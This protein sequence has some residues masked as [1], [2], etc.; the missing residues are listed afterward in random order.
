[1][2][3]PVLH[4][5]GLAAIALLCGIFYSASVPPPAQAQSISSYTGQPPFVGSAVAPNILLLLDNSGSMNNNAYTTVFNTA[6]IYSGVFRNDT[7]Y[8]YASGVFSPDTSTVVTPP[9]I[10][11]NASYPWHG[12][13]LN[14]AAMREVDLVKVV[15]V[16]GYCTTGNRNA[17]GLCSQVKAQ[18]SFSSGACCITQF[19]SVTSA[20]A[21]GLMPASLISATTYFY[22]DGS[23]YPGKFCVS[24]SSTAPTTCTATKLFTGVANHP[25]LTQGVLQ[26]IGTA[27]RFALM[28]FNTS[29]GGNLSANMGSPISTLITAIEATTPSTWTPLGESLYEAVRYYAQISPSFFGTDYTTGVQANDPFYYAA[30]QWSATGQYVNCCKNYVIIFTD[31]QPTQDSSIPSAM[32]D[33]AHTA[34]SHGTS[35]HCS[36]ALGCTAALSHGGS[37]TTST[38]TWHNAHSEHHDNC[39]TYFGGNTSDPCLSAGS[40]IL[41]DVA[42][43]AHTTDLRQASIPI[44]GAGSDLPGLQNLTIYTFFAFGTGANLLKDAAKVGGFIDKNGNGLPDNASEY[45]QVNNITGALGADGVPDN[46]FEAVDAFQL[47]SSLIAT[48]SAILHDSSSGTAVS[49]LSSS[50]TGDG[51]MYQSYFYTSSFNGVNQVTWT[52]YTNGLFLDQYGNI[53]EDTDGDHRLVYTNDYIIQ[54]R[55][56]NVPTSPTYNQTLVDRYIDAN[57][58]GTADSANAAS[59]L[60]LNQLTGIWEAGRQLALTLSA[61]RN[62]ITWV[63]TNH[64]G[65]VDAS[66]Q[67]QFSLANA[68]TLGPYLRAGAAPYTQNAI[69]NFIRGCDPVLEAATCPAA[70]QNALRYR[71]LPVSGSNHIWKYGDP[72]SSSPTVVAAPGERF[73]LRYGDPSYN[74]FLAAYATR[75]EVVY[76]GANDGMLHAFNGGFYNRGDDPTTTSVEHG[77]F[78]N[79]S[80]PA[81][82]GV[83][84][85]DELWGFVPYQLLPQL[86]FLANPSY[87]HVYYVDLKPKVTDVRIFCD[88]GTNLSGN[89]STPPPT[90]I[91]GQAGTSHP[92]GW[93]TILIGGFRMGGSC[94]ACTTNGPPLTVTIGGTPITFYSAYFVLDITNPEQDPVLLWSFSDPTLGLTT[95][96][97]TVVRMNPNGDSTTS[98]TNAKWFA[99]FGSGVTGYDAPVSATLGQT[100]TLFAVDLVKGPGGTG[101]PNVAKMPV[102]TLHGIMGDLVAYDMDLDWRTDAIY[103][104]R[105]Y[106]NGGAPATGKMYRL[107]INNPIAGKT[108]CPSAPCTPATWGVQNGALRSPTEMLVTFPSSNTKY[109]GPILA[110]PIVTTDSSAKTWIYFGTGRYFS[111]PDKTNTETQYLFGLKDSVLN[112]TCPGGGASETSVTGCWDNNLLDVSNAVVCVTCTG[113]QVTGVAGGVTT[114]T[115]TAATSL[116][117]SIATLD[118]WFVTLPTTGER[119]IVTPTLVGGAVFFPTFTP[120]N[121]ICQASG[122]SNLYAL[123]YLTGTAYTTP[124]IGTTASG[125]QTISNRSVSLGSGVASAIS[126]QHTTSA[127]GMTYKSQMSTGNL[128]SGNA[129]VGATWSQYLSWLQQRN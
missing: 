26:Q 65:I 113:N 52:G 40:H 71:Y 105:Q 83:N 7:C 15:M 33:F 124:F 68:G 8:S 46:Y 5:Y 91:Q 21:A 17:Q 98:A 38:A 123:Y 23:N 78:T 111:T 37:A 41:D 32:Y 12:N 115:G 94:G 25:E 125:S 2:K 86:Q 36:A 48:I 29:Q 90:C 42:Y 44:L 51:S 4:H 64:N 70:E 76:V 119:N 110:A 97:P 16:G 6:T 85:G 77:W 101:N 50:S 14:F 28:E 102:G 116:Q 22:L 104:G 9:A 27:A 11:G 18:D 126:L 112:G 47:E 61:N 73:D 45:D 59:T 120:V 20:Q 34:A 35:D 63:D 79:H 99:V 75:R 24:S 43:F 128:V 87:T 107:I 129:A 109:P 55:F 1:M 95:S 69:I 72:I 121:D 60:S 62:L 108:G 56:D 19:Q 122:T 49:V 81:N 117:G 82:R 106:D 84:L 67:M 30:P 127:G 80:T 92:N 96:Y 89:P 114:L 93:G 103:V 57:G 88:S 118:G 66:E 100:T 10:C 54:T 13:L 39:S 58:D 3:R 53:R 31:G 74:D